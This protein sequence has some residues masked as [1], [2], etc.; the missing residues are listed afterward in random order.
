[1]TTADRNAPTKRA[2]ASSRV[3]MTSVWSDRTANVR[4]RRIDVVDDAHGD[5]Q[6]E[7]SAA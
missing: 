1:M 6:V 2:A 5:D 3:A 7:N 4:D